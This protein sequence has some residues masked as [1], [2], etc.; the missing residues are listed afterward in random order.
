MDFD[1]EGIKQERK[2]EVERLVKELPSKQLA[3]AMTEK[4]MQAVGVDQCP[5][6]LLS[7]T[8]YKCPKKKEWWCIGVKPKD[9]LKVIKKAKEAGNGQGKQAS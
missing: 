2:V 7:G 4:C 8:A 1:W 6:R 3:E 5:A 9:W